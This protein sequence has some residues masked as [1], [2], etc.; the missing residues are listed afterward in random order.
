MCLFLSCIFYFVWQI[1]K[2]CQRR[3][4]KQ[5]FKSMYWLGNS[6]LDSSWLNHW[7]WIVP[8]PM[9]VWFL[10]FLS[11][12]W[13][14]DCFLQ[15]NVLPKLI[16][17]TGLLKVTLINSYGKFWLAQSQKNVYQLWIT[18][19][20]QN[21]QFENLHISSHGKARNIKFRYQ[22]NLRGFNGSSASGGSD[23]ITS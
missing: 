5:P 14:L 9:H 10:N 11:N 12:G 22:V 21:D 8:D 23:M 20:Q 4:E 13:S 16:K 6:V 19:S 17:K 1:R 7:T 2:T 15:P 3:N 18:Q